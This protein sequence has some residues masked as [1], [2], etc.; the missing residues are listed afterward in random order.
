MVTNVA[1]LFLLDLHGWQR[2]GH[3]PLEV[4]PS[5]QVTKSILIMKFC[6]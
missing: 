6:T 1:N 5:V 2:F 4:L 3:G